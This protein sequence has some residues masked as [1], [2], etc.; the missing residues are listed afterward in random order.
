MERKSD[1]SRFKALERK[2]LILRWGLLCFVIVELRKHTG[3]SGDDFFRPI[4][5]NAVVLGYNFLISIMVFHRGQRMNKLLQLSLYL[6]I[7]VLT[8]LL[9]VSLSFSDILFFS[10]FLFISYHS[11]KKGLWGLIVTLTESLG[12]LAFITFGNFPVPFASLEVFL[13]RM[14]LLVIGTVIIYEINTLLDITHLKFRKAEEQA[15]KDPLTGLPNRL[16]LEQSF[17]RAVANYQSTRQAF[18][19]AI[20]DIDNFKR[21][22]DEKGHTFGDKVLLILA[23]VLKTNARSN[24]FICRYG[25]EEFLIVFGGCSLE[26]AYLKSDKIREEFAFYNFFDNPV[27]V[28]AGVSLYKE[29]CSMTENINIADEA[30]YAAKASGKNRVTLS[31][32]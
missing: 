4:L 14:L 25:G 20:F 22:N 11:V 9:A 3:F 21:I 29:G 26:D 15:S 23:S 2:F 31:S 16:L 5:T 24:D 12:S 30:L 18:S 27:T 28:S 17:Q 32:I 6:D 7:P 1:L 10:Y 13:N 8:L 19:I